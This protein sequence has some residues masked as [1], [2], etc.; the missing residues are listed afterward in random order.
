MRKQKDI[1]NYVTPLPLLPLLF[2]R[3]LATV[4]MMKCL[5]LVCKEQQI[6]FVNRA[7]GGA[8]PLRSIGLDTRVQQASLK[9][10]G[11]LSSV[12]TSSSFTA[13]SGMNFLS[14]ACA[15]ISTP[16]F[17][18][19]MCMGV[20]SRLGYRF[21][22]GKFSLSRHVTPPPSKG[23]DTKR[24]DVESKPK[25]A[26][27]YHLLHPSKLTHHFLCVRGHK[28]EPPPNTAKMLLPITDYR[29]RAQAG[30]RGVAL[31][32]ARVIFRHLIWS[33]EV[34][35]IV[36]AVS[37][38]HRSSG[39]IVQLSGFWSSSLPSSINR[40]LHDNICKTVCAVDVTISC[41]LSFLYHA[42]ELLVLSN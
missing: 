34:L 28:F 37:P 24:K 27:L 13:G 9:T 30:R 8:E 15:A 11:L 14:E 3:F 17:P 16:R 38:V 39:D 31:E 29:N 2:V 5:I 40:S 19:T 6:W 10:I 21:G 18:S 12:P 35:W 23:E 32:A 26:T 4:T 36:A 1:Q 22:H 25:N 7:A 20:F 42:Q 33:Y 41:H